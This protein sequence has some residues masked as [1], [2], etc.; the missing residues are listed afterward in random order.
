MSPSI[1]LLPTPD[2]PHKKTSV[3]TITPDNDWKKELAAATTSVSVLLAQLGL[4]QLLNK[5]DTR[6]DFRCLVTPG[7]INKMEFG[8]INDPLLLQILPLNEEMMH[9]PKYMVGRTLLVT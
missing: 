8:N 9:L 5:V 7:F 1:E 6:P 2:K 4:E 3:Q